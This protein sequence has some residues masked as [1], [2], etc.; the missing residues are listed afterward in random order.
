MFFSLTKKLQ[1][2][3]QTT[4]RRIQ[5]FYKIKLGQAK[6]R[7]LCMNW[8]RNGKKIKESTEKWKWIKPTVFGFKRNWGKILFMYLIFYH[9]LIYS[10]LLMMMPYHLEWF[11]HFL[12]FWTSTQKIWVK[13]ME[14]MWIWIPKEKGNV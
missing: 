9:V 8:I 12:R 11:I 5:G 2:W 3:L 13:N 7:V 1:S 6:T 4:F 14:Q 10:F